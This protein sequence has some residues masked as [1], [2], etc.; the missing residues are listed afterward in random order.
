[1]S[2]SS[3]GGEYRYIRDWTRERDFL[4]PIRCEDINCMETNCNYALSQLDE[5][6][7]R[8]MAEDMGIEY[9]HMAQQSNID[10][11]LREIQSGIVINMDGEAHGFADI[12]VIFAAP[13]FL[14]LAYELINFRRRLIV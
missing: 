13:L 12:Y 1:M 2:V 5:D 9:I 6:N 10:N 14:L 11:K 8:Q 4:D 7:L 3:W